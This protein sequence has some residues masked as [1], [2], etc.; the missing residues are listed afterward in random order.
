M[1]GEQLI[2]TAVQE[3]SRLY[4]VT[5]LSKTIALILFILL[6][7]L[8][9]WIGYVYAPV[10]IIETQLTERE[11]V[12][13]AQTG[14]EKKVL[15]ENGDWLLYE[16]AAKTVLTDIDNFDTFQYQ[17]T[18]LPLGYTHVDLIDFAAVRISH[19]DETYRVYMF[20]FDSDGNYA[21]IVDDKNDIKYD[22]LYPATSTALWYMNRADEPIITL[23]SERNVQVI[24]VVTGAAEVVY[25]ESEDTIQ[26]L[27]YCRYGA[28]EKLMHGDVY[29]GNLY[30]ARYRLQ[31]TDTELPLDLQQYQ[32]QFEDVIEISIPTDFLPAGAVTKEEQVREWPEFENVILAP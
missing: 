22:Y 2:H 13:S 20:S 9:G 19:V 28:C 32:Y 27:T 4:T 8:G 16:N 26:L 24:N 31:H 17:V 6:P 25:T 3:K 5:K 10:Q 7:F 30:V 11:T 21:L 23:V 18:T 1:D 14:S 12:S 29:T 15:L